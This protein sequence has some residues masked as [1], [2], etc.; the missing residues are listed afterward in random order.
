[1]IESIR[2]LIVD[3]EAPARI[4]LREV[5]ADCAGELPVM[6]MG[7]ASS[8]RAALDWLAQNQADVILLDIRMPEMD[9]IELA[10]HMQKLKNPPAVIFCTAY[11]QHAIEAFEVNAIDYLLKPVR[12]ERLVMALQKVRMYSQAQIQALSHQ[13]R[14]QLGVS[15]GGKV[16]LIPVAD[17]VYMRAEQKYVTIRTLAHEYLTEES[18][19]AL[20]Q[21]FGE[22]FVRIHRNC[23]VAKDFIAGYEKHHHAGED[24]AGGSG[25]AV[26]LRGLEE[27]L[28]IS[29][30]HRHIIKEIAG[31]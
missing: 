24:E 26:M 18:L 21:E 16:L 31:G 1:M 2:I 29:R 6:V 27:R 11:D 28:P 15:V 8:G 13:S 4:R 25:W 22:R 12:R 10:R 14:T 9:G 30:R 17:I 7:E 5:L 19:V 20:E 3:D 23:I